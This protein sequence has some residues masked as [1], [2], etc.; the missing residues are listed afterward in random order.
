VQALQNASDLSQSSSQ[1]VQPSEKDTTMN[2]SP[3]LH[4]I[5]PNQGYQEP[6][7][8]SMWVDNKSRPK[9][10]AIAIKRNNRRPEECIAAGLSEA[11][12]EQMYDWATWRMYNRIVDHRRNQRQTM[13][14][15]LPPLV[16]M[17]HHANQMLPRPDMHAHRFESRGAA[18]YI[19]DGE[20]FDL[21]F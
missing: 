2:S 14:T 5:P 9:S 12:S 3:T 18:D 19:H 11:S 6:H 16:A 13:R 17:D 7:Q 21:D 20:V 4:S 8:Q 1:L 10:K 15:S